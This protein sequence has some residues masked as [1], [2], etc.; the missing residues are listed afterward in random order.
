VTGSGFPAAEIDQTVANGQSYTATVT[1]TPVEPAG[2]PSGWLKVTNDNST[3]VYVERNNVQGPQTF[4]FT[5][6]TP[7]VRVWA[8]TPAGGTPQSVDISN[9]T[10]APAP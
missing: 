6:T 1:I 3:V 9:L 2:Q 7:L 8:G 10:F 5:A 4:T